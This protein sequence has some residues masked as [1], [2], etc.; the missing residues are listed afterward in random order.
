[1]IH[2]APRPERAG[3]GRAPISPHWYWLC[4]TG[5]DFRLTPLLGDSTQCLLGFHPHSRILLLNVFTQL[6][7]PAANFEQSPCRGSGV[8]GGELLFILAWCELCSLS[9]WLLKC[10]VSSSE[11]STC[12]GFFSFLFTFLAG[13]YL[14][15][16]V[17]SRLAQNNM[18]SS[19]K[20]YHP[21]ENKA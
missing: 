4:L 12:P 20:N 2:E 3:A 11:S 8:V 17:S 15:N 13:W 19:K 7:I 6:V 21:R 16:F 10:H 1:M 5:S 14:W 9:I 18:S